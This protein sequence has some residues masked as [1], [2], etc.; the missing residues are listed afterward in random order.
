MI[1]GVSEDIIDRSYYDNLVNDAADTIAKYGDLDWF[2]SD[3]PIP[4]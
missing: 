3:D 4:N 2:L 1:K